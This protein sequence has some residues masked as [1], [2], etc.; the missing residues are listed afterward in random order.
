MLIRIKVKF[1]LLAIVF[2]FI[3]R[4]GEEF[5]DVILG[6]QRTAQNSHNLHNWSV[7]LEVMLNDSDEAVCDDGNV[8][9]DTYRI[10]TLSPEILDLEVLLDSLEEQL[11]LPPIFV[12]EC[13]VLACKIE[14]VRVVS[15]C[16]MLVRSIVDDTP[17]VAWELLFV[18]LLRK[19]D[20]LVTQDIVLSVENV[21]AINDLIVWVFFL[22]DDKES[23]G[24]CN[25]VKSGEIKVA[26]VKDIACQ[27]LVGDPV[28]RIDIMHV[29]IGDAVEHGNLRD[30]IHLSMDLDARLRAS[31]LLPGK[32]RHTEVDSR[33][34]HCIKPTEQLKFSCNPSLL[35]KEYHVESKLLK[36][37]VVSEVVSLGKRTLVDGCL[38][39]SEMK[40]LLSMSSCYIF[41]F[42]QPLATHKLSEHKD[43]Q[44]AP[45]RWSPI[46]GSVAGLDDK[47][48]E[49]SLWKKAGYL[50][51][52]VL[53]EM[54]ICPNFDL[55]E[56]SAFQKCDMAFS[57]LLYCT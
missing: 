57:N 27:W 29:G 7:Q 11:D 1:K 36:D 43:E 51:E 25:L 6:E 41:E 45:V 35:R 17:D 46:L 26:S 4:R 38:S 24:H 42:S 23:S 37:A 55:G 5:H 14:V 30:D 34:V 9:L 2:F 39:K 16:A 3:V 53:P 56:K 15:E 47:A 18:L 52:N 22:T 40:R 12:K 21:F 49:V 10:V 19:D 20:S 54:H 8:D 13:N 48:F 33:G 44:L 28:H 31:E 50:S 32:E